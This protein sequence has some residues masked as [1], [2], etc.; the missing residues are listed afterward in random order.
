MEVLANQTGTPPTKWKNKLISILYQVSKVNLGVGGKPN[1]IKVFQMLNLP[2]FNARQNFLSNKYIGKLW[3]NR[4]TPL[5][6]TLQL[7][8]HKWN[9]GKSN[10]QTTLTKPAFI[11]SYHRFFNMDYVQQLPKPPLY[12]LDYPVIIQKI[13][14]DLTTFSKSDIDTS[15]EI[16]G[17]QAL[18]GNTKKEY[19]TH[20]Y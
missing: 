15:Q 17:I 6:A 8:T 7:A 20:F 12:S 10:R 18:Q 4:F 5:C 19:H 3:S 9:L 2:N 16:H 1:K 11:Q 14:N 13:E